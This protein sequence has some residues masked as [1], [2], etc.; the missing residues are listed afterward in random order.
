MCSLSLFSLFSEAA[1]RGDLWRKLFLRIHMK[2][3]SWSLFLM[4]LQAFR[5][6]TLLER[7]SNTGVL[8]CHYCESFKNTY[9]EEHLRT[10]A[11]VYSND[12]LIYLNCVIK[13]MLP[14]RFWVYKEKC[15]LQRKISFV[16]KNLELLKK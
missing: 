6:S 16:K 13:N 5:S 7:D 15:H 11:S 3:P 12:L 10:A 14:E 9:F 4:K 2:I 1:T 8:Y